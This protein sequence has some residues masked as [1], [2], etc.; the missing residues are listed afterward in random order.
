MKINKPCAINLTFGKVINIINNLLVGHHQ[1]FELFDIVHQELLEAS[2]QHVLCLLVTTI[3]NVG[4]QHL[5][6]ESPADSVVNTSGFTPVL[7]FKYETHSWIITQPTFQIQT[8]TWPAGYVK[9]PLTLIF[10][11]RSD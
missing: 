9:K 10:T 5:T 2:G 4:H 1:D 8:G 7:L 3:T 11:Y 6:L